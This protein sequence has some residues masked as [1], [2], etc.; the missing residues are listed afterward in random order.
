MRGTTAG[1]LVSSGSDRFQILRDAVRKNPGARHEYVRP[2]LHDDRHGLH[3][4]PSID[5]ECRLESLPVDVRSRLAIF[6]SRS[7]SARNGLAASNG[8][9]GFSTSPGAMPWSR[10]SLNVSWTS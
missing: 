8:V 7:A 2:R 1:R 9:A 3:L 4:D 10:I 5:L 6:G